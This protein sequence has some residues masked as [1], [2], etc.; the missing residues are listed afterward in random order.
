MPNKYTRDRKYI[1][2]AYYGFPKCQY[3]D[4]TKCI[5]FVI[6]VHLKRKHYNSHLSLSIKSPVEDICGCTVPDE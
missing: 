4:T 5:R 6:S 2:S 3:F 1:V